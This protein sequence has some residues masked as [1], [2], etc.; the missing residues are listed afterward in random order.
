MRLTLLEVRRICRAIASE[1]HQVA[2]GRV[3]ASDGGSDHVE[4]LLTVHLPDHGPRL[5]EALV[6]RTDRETF[7]RDLRRRIAALTLSP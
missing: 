6:S 2:I 7:E 4:I 1:N 3:A 5:V